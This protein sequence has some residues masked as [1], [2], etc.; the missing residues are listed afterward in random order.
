VVVVVVLARPFL[1][2]RDESRAPRILSRLLVSTGTLWCSGTGFLK[3][4]LI[5]PLHPEA[6]SGALPSHYVV[7]AGCLSINILAGKQSS[8]Y[9]LTP[10]SGLGAE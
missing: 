9:E 10:N 8:V 1:E 5:P 3:Y 7:T 6:F 2:S 4:L